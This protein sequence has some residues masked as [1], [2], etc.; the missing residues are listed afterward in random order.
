VNRSSA[1]ALLAS[2]A[3]LLVSACAVLFE[4]PRVNIANVRVLS[5]GLIGGTAEVSLNVVNPNGFDLTAEE[6]R[7]RLSFADAESVSGWRTLTQGETEKAVEVAA[8]D[9]TTVRLEM[10]FR[11]SDL[12]RAVTSLLGRGELQYRLDGDVKFDAPIRDMRVPFDR[13]G[14]FAP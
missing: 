10:P 9:S 14:S 11:F 2:C 1:R 3:A 6:V 4:S 12:G 5:V 8:K 7:Y 13:R